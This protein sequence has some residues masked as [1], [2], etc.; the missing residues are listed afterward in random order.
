M[1]IVE[2]NFIKQKAQ[3]EYWPKGSKSTSSRNSNNITIPSEC[4]QGKDV[5]IAV[6]M[7]VTAAIVLIAVVVTVHNVTGTNVDIVIF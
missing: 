2:E 3:Y 1:F 6:A 5:M 7:M 4:L